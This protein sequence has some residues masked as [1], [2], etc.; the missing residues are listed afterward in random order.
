MAVGRSVA[1]TREA[2][3]RTA[4]SAIDGASISVA[5]AEFGRKDAAVERLKSATM[6]QFMPNHSGLRADR[7]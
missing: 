4:L 2:A 3:L 6:S 1:R 7:R 5:S